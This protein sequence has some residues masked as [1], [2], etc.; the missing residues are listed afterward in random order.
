[1]RI[2]WAGRC[3]WFL[4][5]AL[6][7]NVGLAQITINEATMESWA[8]AQTDA[9]PQY[10]Y[11]IDNYDELDSSATVYTFNEYGQAPGYSSSATVGVEHDS[12]FSSGGMNL[13]GESYAY[14][15]D[16]YGYAFCSAESQ[17]G[18]YVTFTLS[19]ES[20]V[21]VTGE[22]A[23]SGYTP[24]D[25]ETEF[26]LR[27][28]GQPFL[29]FVTQA[30]EIDFDQVL[31]AGTYQ[32][33]VL[34]RVMLEIDFAGGDVYEY[35][36]GT[37]DISLTATAVESAV[38]DFL[39]VRHQITA[40][41]VGDDIGDSDSVTSKKYEEFQESV[42]VG[43]FGSTAESSLNSFLDDE[44]GYFY[45]YGYAAAGLY[46]QGTAS[47]D[48]TSDFRTTFRLNNSGRIELSGAVG[49]SDFLGSEVSY[50]EPGFAQVLVR[51]RDL[52]NAVNVVNKVITMNGD[53]PGGIKQVNL[54][55][56]FASVALPAGR[57]RLILRVI[58]N[59]DANN[60]Q[61][62]DSLAVAFMEVE[63]RLVEDGQ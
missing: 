37:F 44:T 32:L 31:P 50:D 23:F 4:F 17:T 42:D 9:G 16:D 54:E 11:E 5:C 22:L 12:T 49:V 29:T 38:P 24:N 53:I 62:E 3:V 13:T 10:N 19:Q 43:M 36:R 47:A 2:T 28:S 18:A 45:S 61:V 59:D 41:F 30:G 51:V 8:L 55:D 52:D 14:V 35:S 7:C 40:S 56:E 60:E 34:S 21:Q 63:G 58:A 39:N 25:F 6:M 26:S 48:A 15:S 46:I 1:M 20:R 27:R 33:A 57:Y